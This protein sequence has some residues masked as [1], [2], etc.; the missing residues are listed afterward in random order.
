M[1]VLEL[2]AGTA[3]FAKVAR[4][5]GHDVRTLDFDPQFKC[6]YTMNIM[7][8]DA[9]TLGDWKPDVIWASIPCDCFSVA[10]I[11]SNWT[12]GKEAYIPKRPQSEMAIRIAKKTLEIIDML[13]PKAYIIENPMGVLR[14]MD[15]MQKYNR[16]TVTYCQYG[17]HVMKPTDL[18]HNLD[19]FV[20]RRCKNGMPCHESAP[21]GA[22]TGTQGK[23][24]K[25]LRAVVPPQ[26]CLEI[27]EV[28]E[29]MYKTP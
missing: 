17:D 1:K 25:T 16:V 9:N 24:N 29:Q 18:W 13:Q 4:A 2:F 21:R 5:H 20:A 15:F 7:D 6:D 28:C 26:L 11:G 10:S 3:S 23:A 8:F 22:K 27:L 14:K 19:N 12:G